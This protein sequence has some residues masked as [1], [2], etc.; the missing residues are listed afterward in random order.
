MKLNETAKATL[1]EAGISPA[2]WARMHFTDGKWY[3]DACGC[4]D[5]RCIGHH[6]DAG[7]DCRCLPAMLET[8]SDGE[9]G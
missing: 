4:T 6:H 8:R 3:G 1:R 7:D 2:A 9:S 5:D